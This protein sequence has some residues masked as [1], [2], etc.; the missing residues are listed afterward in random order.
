MGTG[1]SRAVGGV[2]GIFTIVMSLLIG[3]CS[4]H[5][6]FRSDDRPKYS[7]T[8]DPVELESMRQQGV[9]ILDVRLIEDFSADPVLIPEAVYKN[10]DNISTWSGE[11]SPDDGPVIVYCV[12]GK[13]VSQKAASILNNQGFEVYSLEGGIKGWQSSGRPIAHVE[14]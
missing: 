6:D 11:M 10:P 14:P 5:Y 12:Q 4:S 8:V 13:W 9:R 7:N 3:G 2:A 1:I